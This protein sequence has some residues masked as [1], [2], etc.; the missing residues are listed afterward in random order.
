MLFTVFLRH[1]HQT[2][3]Y[4]YPEEWEKIKDYALS[5]DYDI[6]RG[7][8]PRNIKHHLDNAYADFTMVFRVPSDPHTPSEESDLVVT[9]WERDVPRD[10]P[11]STSAPLSSQYCMNALH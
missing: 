2:T 6:T 11:F 5:L 8:I 1:G 4:Q 7:G 3:Q 9:A 10:Y